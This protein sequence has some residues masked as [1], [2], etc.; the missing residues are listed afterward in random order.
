[1]STYPAGS[2]FQATV[3]AEGRLQF[4]AEERRALDRSLQTL[5]GQ[6]VAIIVK[7]QQRTRSDRAN[8]YYWATVVPILA[9]HCGYDKQEMH[10]ALAMRFLRI[11]D[12]PITGAPRRKRTPDTSTREFAEY[13]DAC[14]RLAGEL[15]LSIPAPNEAVNA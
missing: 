8:S 2:S 13:V 7:R 1:M 11:D 15:G 4:T 5:A 9:D 10:E 12:C 3:S 14:I 6:T